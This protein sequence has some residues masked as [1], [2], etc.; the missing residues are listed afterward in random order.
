[1]AEGYR[2]L[3]EEEVGTEQSRCGYKFTTYLCH[4]SCEKKKV[5][6]L[7]SALRVHFPHLQNEDKSVKF[8]G[9]L[10]E[11]DA[12]KLKLCTV[13]TRSVHP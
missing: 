11:Q 1:V 3:N 10:Q 12:N 5:L 2:T 9:V 13:L 4:Y 7:A 8:T 6:P